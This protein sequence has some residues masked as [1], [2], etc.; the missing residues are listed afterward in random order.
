MAD[1]ATDLFIGLTPDAVLD[2]IE[3]L[4]MPCNNVCYALNSF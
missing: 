4:G 1:R 2:A 3:T